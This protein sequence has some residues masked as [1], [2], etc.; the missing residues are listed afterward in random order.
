VQPG[1]HPEYGFQLTE[2]ALAIRTSETGRKLSR[3]VGMNANAELPEDHAFDRL[4]VVGGGLQVQDGAG[5]VLAAYIPMEGDQPTGNA[6]T[7]MIM[8]S[9]PLSYL[10]QPDGNWRFA[11]L[12]GGQDDH[13]GAGIGEFRAV[14]PQASEWFGGGNAGGGANVYDI[15]LSR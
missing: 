15:L 7:G 4:I 13:G 3:R 2:L 14:Q 11:L 6:V 9:I 5:N 10:G 1:W 12:A 8:F